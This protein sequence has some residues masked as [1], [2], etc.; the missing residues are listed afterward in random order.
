M[1]RL[2]NDYYHMNLTHLKF[3]T[4]DNIAYVEINR[5][6]KRN[7]LNDILIKEITETFMQISK[8]QS[9]KAAILTG[10]ENTFCSGADLEYLQNIS[11]H[12]IEENQDDSKKL[13]RMYQSIYEC[14]KPVIGMVDGPA[15]AGGCG[16]ATVCDFI[17]A[18]KENAKFGYPE[19]KIGFIPAI[20]LIYLIKRIGE[21][22]ARNLVLSG[23][24]ISSEEAKQIN[25]INNFVNTKDL[26]ELTYTFTRELI[27]N[28][29]ATAM[30]LCK[31]M[32]VSYS[33]MDTKQALEYAAN[34]NAIS[35]MTD[36]CKRGINSFLKKEKIKW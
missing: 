19:V 36:D 22:H 4:A 32:F 6:E 10:S 23:K 15:L 33:N 35:R 12:S 2:N 8:N 26:K 17:F 31:E 1:R 5:P 25:L 18:S 14:R 3:S 21:G 20:V 24:I 16:L 7:A 9:V 34:L 11:Q 30:S 29:S 28:N 27:A 13:L